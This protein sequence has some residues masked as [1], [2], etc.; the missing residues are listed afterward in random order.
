MVARRR[1]ARFVEQYGGASDQLFGGSDA[2]DQIQAEITL[3]SGK[4]D[5]TTASHW[6][7]PIP[8]V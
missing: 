3:K 6:N 8:I 2:T 7:M 5:T 4:H 1:L